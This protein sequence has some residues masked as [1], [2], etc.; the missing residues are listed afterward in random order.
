[1]TSGTARFN[2][3]SVRCAIVDLDGTMIDT[4]GDLVAALNPALAQ[5]FIHSCPCVNCRI[6]FASLISGVSFC[7][8]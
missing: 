6:F 8:H 7:R 5:I 4:A 3:N 1:M 2:R